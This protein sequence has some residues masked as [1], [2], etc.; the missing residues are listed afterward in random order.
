MDKIK[1]Y[2]I[3]AVELR[4]GNH[5]INK[6]G[7][8]DVVTSVGAGFCSTKKAGVNLISEI[9]QVPLTVM[10]LKNYGFKKTDINELTVEYGK[11]NFY[12]KVFDNEVISLVCS[13]TVFQ[14]VFNSVHK[15]QN[16]YYELTNTIL[17]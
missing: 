7:K 10:W 5:V 3:N 12:L 2:I 1:N 13:D 15:L 4:V 14:I 17:K 9:S 6:H 11:G 8:E 16:T